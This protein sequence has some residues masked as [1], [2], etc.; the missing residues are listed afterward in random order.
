[1]GVCLFAS[2]AQAEECFANNTQLAPLVSKNYGRSVELDRDEVTPSDVYA[3]LLRV[4]KIL[5][6]IGIE[7]VNHAQSLPIKTALPRTNF[8]LVHD[9]YALVQNWHQQKSGYVFAEPQLIVPENI[10]PIHVY[11]WVDATYAYLLC[12][13]T[14]QSSTFYSEK[15]DKTITPLDVFYLIE[16]VINQLVAA[17]NN[18]QIEHLISNRVRQSHLFVQELA[19]SKNQIRVANWELLS[20]QF[21]INRTI[22]QLLI[23]TLFN[24]Q[25]ITD[26]D[27]ISNLLTLDDAN[28]Q[29]NLQMRYLL[30]TLI[31]TELKLHTADIEGPF[32]KTL[33]LQ[34]LQAMS[35]T[36]VMSRLVDAITL[37]SED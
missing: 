18:S 9:I 25:K 28:E 7:P 26:V 17:L 24:V 15:I 5:N 21:E 6:G 27:Y 23:E 16:D 22:N 29:S 31:Y 37:L 36:E 30:S 4:Q 35:T 2:L 34:L 13:V 10:K 32:A 8:V 12:N 1:M 19:L 11:Q 20:D 3:H 14:P 33:N